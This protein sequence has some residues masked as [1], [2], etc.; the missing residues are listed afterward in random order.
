MANRLRLAVDR[1]MTTEETGPGAQARGRGPLRTPKQLAALGGLSL[2]LV[3]A[4]C[5]SGELRHH[6]VG[7]PGRR[8]KI[9]IADADW[10]AYLAA[11]RSGGDRV[12]AVPARRPA[13]PTFTHLKVRA[14]SGSR[15]PAGAGGP[16]SGARS[17]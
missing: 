9:L 15:P 4:L 17:A 7:A 10:E 5:A 13:S 6:R 11:H 8:G 1:M 12:A 2:N 3:Y 14:A 16:A